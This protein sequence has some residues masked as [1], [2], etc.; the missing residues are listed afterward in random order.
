MSR[1]GQWTAV[2]H[3]RVGDRLRSTGH[4]VVSVA[5]VRAMTRS[6]HMYNLTVSDVHTYYVIAGDAPVLVHN[7]GCGLPVRI[8]AGQQ[9]AG[10]SYKMTKAKLG[11]VSDLLKAKPNFQIFRTDGKASMGDFLVIDLSDANNPVGWSV[12]LKTSSGGFPGEQF[13]NASSLKS[14]YGLTQLRTVAGTPSEMLDALNV[15]R[16]SWN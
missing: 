9:V 2:D 4:T 8:K 11:F 13:R 10:G 14:Q 7:I 16:G 1:P 3:L 5:S 15:G 6:Q 12:E